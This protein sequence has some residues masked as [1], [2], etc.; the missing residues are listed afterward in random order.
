[1]GD[2]VWCGQG[3]RGGGLGTLVRL[4]LRGFLCDFPGSCF[5]MRCFGNDNDR[6]ARF[7]LIVTAELLS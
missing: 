4:L 3:W 6:D 1:M 2:L 5:V 7:E